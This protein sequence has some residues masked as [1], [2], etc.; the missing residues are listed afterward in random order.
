MRLEPH[1]V[2]LRAMQAGVKVKLCG[3][4]MAMYED[5]IGVFGTRTCGTEVEEVFMPFADYS[6]NAF[7]LDC[8]MI[9]EDDLFV[10][11]CSGALT[12]LN[13]KKRDLSGNPNEP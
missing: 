4:E 7:I 11:G 10:M 13:Q 9:H 8:K 12:R 5:Q 2:V 6:L 1:V 3:R